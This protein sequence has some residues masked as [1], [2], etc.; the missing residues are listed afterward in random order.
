MGIE[1]LGFE[2]EVIGLM[3][4]G[5]QESSYRAVFLPG[6]KALKQQDSIVY[7]SSGF[8]VGEF[9]NMRHGEKDIS[10]RLHKLINSASAVSHVALLFYV[11]DSV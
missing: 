11:T 8:S 4:P 9:V 5:R 1:M 3:P 7:S 10:C 6:I 2:S